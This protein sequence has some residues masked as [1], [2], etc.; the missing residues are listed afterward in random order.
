MDEMIADHSY[1]YSWEVAPRHMTKDLSSNHNSHSCQKTGPKH[2]VPEE[3]KEKV[4]QVVE[5]IFATWA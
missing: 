3:E 5:Q 1:L 2:L 4:Q